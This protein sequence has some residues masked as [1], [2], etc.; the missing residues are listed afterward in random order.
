MRTLVAAALMTTLISP[1]FAIEYNKLGPMIKTP[2][3]GFMDRGWHKTIKFVSYVDHKQLLITEEGIYYIG[4]HRVHTNEGGDKD[5]HRWGFRARCA[6]HPQFKDKLKLALFFQDIKAKE[7]ETE[8]EI[9]PTLENPPGSASIGW[10][11]LWSF[12]CRGHLFPNL[13]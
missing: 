13:Q 6:V 7:P 9:D 8:V 10:W 5:I 2:N 1:S 4:T 11:Q 3:K 12:V